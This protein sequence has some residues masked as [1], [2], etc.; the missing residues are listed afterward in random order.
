MKL[1][2]RAV[3]HEAT[4]AGVCG[5]DVSI[6]ER[7]SDGC[8]LLTSVVDAEKIIEA[9]S[10]ALGVDIP[11]APVTVSGEGSRTVSWLSP[12]S[13]LMHVPENEAD[14]VIEAVGQAFP[15]RRVHASPYSDHIC[16]FDIEGKGAEVLLRQG[17]F[18]SLERKGLPVNAVKRT[19]VAGMPLLVR[20][21]AEGGW[22]VGVERS[23]AQYFIDW[24]IE[25][26]K[27]NSRRVVG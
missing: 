4:L 22:R 27:D 16:W 15:E 12:R 13:W 1:Q 6:V 25:T 20:R 17:G 8:I 3:I 18:I 5:E 14:N 19:L 24:M 26:Q 2:A 23:R 21:C 9:L 10:Q 7:G 11:T